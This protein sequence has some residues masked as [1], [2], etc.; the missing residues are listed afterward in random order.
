[1]M[2][3]RVLST[4]T[5]GLHGEPRQADWLLYEDGQMTRPLRVLSD[6]EVDSLLD[7][8]DEQRKAADRKR[9]EPALQVDGTVRD[10]SAIAD[11]LDHDVNLRRTCAAAGLL[12]EAAARGT[13]LFTTKEER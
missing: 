7:Q 12:L 9:S 5:S 3:L 8:I 6:G 13:K 4:L 11:D 1:M 10:L 2:I